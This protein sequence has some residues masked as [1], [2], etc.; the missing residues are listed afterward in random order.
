MLFDGVRSSRAASCSRPR[1][2]RCS[3]AGRSRRATPTRTSRT[4]K[5]SSRRTRAASRSSSGSSSGSAFAPSSATCGTCSTTPR[6][7]CA[8]RSRGLR[9]GR[10]TVELDGGE[11]ISVAV[12]VE[13]RPPARDRRLLGHVAGERRQLQR[14]VVDRA[15][16]RAVRVPHAGAREHPAERRLPRAAD[17]RAAGGLPARSRAIRPP[18]SPATSRRR[19]A[20][21]TRCSPRSTPAPARKAR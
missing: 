1:C 5:R 17:D 10:F 13:R 19:S 21:P 8:P 18:S 9:D 7:A 12:T 2:A 15:R 4:S 16:G 20:S 11:R 6:R 14:A 3:R